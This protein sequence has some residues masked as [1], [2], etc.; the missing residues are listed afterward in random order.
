MEQLEGAVEAVLSG[1]C[2]ASDCTWRYGVPKSTVYTHVKARRE[3]RKVN[4]PG[5]IHSYTHPPYASHDD[6]DD[7]D[8][9][10]YGNIG[11]QQVLSPEREHTLCEYIR[12]MDAEKKPQASRHIRVRARDLAALDGKRFGTA[13]GLPSKKWL[14]AF[15]K[16]KGL[17]SL[18]TKRR[19]E[20][21]PL[22]SLVVDWMSYYMSIF[23]R[24]GRDRIYNYDESGFSR[25]THRGWV[26]VSQRD[27]SKRNPPIFAGKEW[28]DHITLCVIVSA[29]C[30]VLPLIWIV[31]GT[32]EQAYHKI[33][34]AGAKG[35][36]IIATGNYIN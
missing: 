10:S 26:V 16:R 11:R 29:S 13:N 8:C 12:L 23:R 22:R 27:H 36:Y 35:V 28:A 33:A 30:K 1:E 34:A 5:Y 17:H 21:A 18:L 2:G 14:V 7:D 6:D 4:A 24:Y 15:K 19:A 9:T 31:K 20:A 3:G 25:F 32:T